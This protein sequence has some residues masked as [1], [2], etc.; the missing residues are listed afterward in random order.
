MNELAIKTNPVVEDMRDAKERDV[1][2][3]MLA[4]LAVRFRHYF[5]VL[6]ALGTFF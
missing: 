2:L 1:R 3:S 4:C 5:S 6:N